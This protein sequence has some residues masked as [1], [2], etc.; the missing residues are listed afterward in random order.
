VSYLNVDEIESALAALTAAY[1][2][3]T[4]LIAC[5]NP[6]HESRPTHI[7]RIGRAGPG[8]D[9]LLLLGGVHARE[10]VPPD[11]LVSLAADLLEADQR[12]TGLTYGGKRFTAD[13]VHTVV[14]Q[15][16]VYVFPCVN[17]DGRRHS[18]TA[19]PMWRK[20]RRPHPNGGGCVGVDINR[21]FGFLWDH[22]T[23]FAAGSGVRTSANPCDRDVYRGPAEASEPETRNVVWALD[24]LPGIRWLV[25]VHSAVP[26]ILYSWG[27]DQNQTTKPEQNFRNTAFDGVRGRPNDTA[28]GEYITA[29]DLERCRGVSERMGNA[30]RAVRGD[31]YGVEQAY[32]L[33][34]T[35]GAS[36]DYAF[37]RHLADAAR[38]KVFGFTIEC[39]HTFQPAWTEAE[40][41]I[42]EVSAALV[43]LCQEV[44]ADNLV[45]AATAGPHIALVRQTPGWQT[46]PVSFSGGD[47]T[48]RVTNG[49]ASP[50]IT[51]WAHQPGVRVVPGDFNGNG[52]TD[53][54]LVRQTPGWASIPIAFANGDGTWTIT[55]GPAPQFITDWAHQPGVRVI[56]G[57]FNGNGLTDIALIRQTPGWASIPIAFANGNGTWTITNGSAAEFAGW[58]QQPGVRVA[59]GDYHG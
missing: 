53:L 5:P 26:V 45:G 34:P 4:E 18:Q 13:E 22:Q 47:G 50:F 27:S 7:L 16:N 24:A 44:A 17:P 21:N 55:N 12:G 20:N 57:D 29:A 48:W 46:I 11:A 23:K 58:A 39:G 56:T 31:D 28:Y 30:V 25:D 51:D 33:Y 41:V 14:E 37:S 52:L 3:S 54:A 10:W 38:G 35:S 8:A 36:D 49:P 59:A 9:G 1:P 43:T 6:T 19:E 15:V 32:G 42:R 2:G 40:A